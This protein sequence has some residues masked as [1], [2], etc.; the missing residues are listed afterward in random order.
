MCAII[1]EDGQA[2]AT[3]LH[4]FV[5]TVPVVFEFG[6]PRCVFIVHT[7]VVYFSKSSELITKCSVR[8]ILPEK[9]KDKT[10]KKATYRFCQE[11]KCRQTQEFRYPSARTF[12]WEIR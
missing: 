7:L 5:E 1:F 9:Y 10:A 8:S 3:I 2:L 12:Q 6:T 11:H 4:Q